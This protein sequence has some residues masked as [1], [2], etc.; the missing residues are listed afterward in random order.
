MALLA[1]SVTPSVDLSSTRNA[2]LDA[3]ERRFAEGRVLDQNVSF[4]ETFAE[5]N[6]RDE[7]D[8]THAAL[9]EILL[10]DFS[11]NFG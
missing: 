2:I 3:A 7:R 1:T 11:F 9:P 6:E 5:M 10:N 8:S 4:A